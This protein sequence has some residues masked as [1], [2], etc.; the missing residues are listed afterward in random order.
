MPV[1]LFL[2]PLIN[3]RLLKG[4]AKSF[5]LSMLFPG[6]EGT[7]FFIAPAT[8]RQPARV[9]LAARKQTGQPEGMTGAMGYFRRVLR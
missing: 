6:G 3:Q 1:L 2:P 5:C 4:I 8:G 9:C 7:R